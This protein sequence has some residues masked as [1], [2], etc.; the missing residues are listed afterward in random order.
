VHSSCENDPIDL[1]G[2][3]ESVVDS[4]EDLTDS[5]DVSAFSPMGISLTLPCSFF[6][7]HVVSHVGTGH[8]INHFPHIIFLT[9]RHIPPIFLLEGVNG[10]TGLG[11]NH[12]KMSHTARAVKM[13]NTTN[14]LALS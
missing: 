4:D 7:R 13:Y 12:K 5:M 10:F 6:F 9:P 2:L 14:I 8:H 11:T 3:H 1:N